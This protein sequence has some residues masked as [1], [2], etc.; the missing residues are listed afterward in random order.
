M[1]KKLTLET[2]ETSSIGVLNILKS[3]TLDY[4]LTYKIHEVEEIPKR[5]GSSNA[6][7]TVTLFG[8]EENLENFYYEQIILEEDTVSFKEIL[9]ESN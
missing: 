8:P 4:N 9:L 5:D 1:K 2:P 3:A 7:I 6:V